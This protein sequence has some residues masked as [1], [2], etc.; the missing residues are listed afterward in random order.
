MAV[1]QSHD[2]DS[3]TATYIWTEQTGEDWRWSVDNGAGTQTLT[4]FKV[5]LKNNSGTPTQVIQAHVWDNASPSNIKFTSTNTVTGS[6]L[7]SSF[8]E[9][10]FLFDSVTVGATDSIGFTAN[11][12]LASASVS[13]R[14]NRSETNTHSTANFA[15]APNPITDTTIWVS[16]SYMMSYS[17]ADSA[18]PTSTGTRLPPPPIVLGGL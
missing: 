10:S 18:T 8:T 12:A 13:I 6:D 16:P 7:T 9:F 3:T 11:D 2:N 5:K 1:W 15:A 17:C 14:A 4:T